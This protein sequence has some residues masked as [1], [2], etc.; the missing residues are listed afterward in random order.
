MK[1][2]VEIKIITLGASGVGKTS[3]IKRIKFGTFAEKNEAT[4]GVDYFVVK[5]K[6]QN[7]NIMI[8]LKYQDTNGL[9]SMQGIIPQQYIRDSQIVLLVFS[10]INTLNEVINRWYSFY[11]ENANIDKSKFILIGNKKDIFG[12]EKEEIERQGNQFAEEIDAHFITCSAKSA[13]NMD[14]LERYI[15]TEAKKFIDENEKKIVD[16]L[17][18][19]N[20]N[21]IDTKKKLN[22]EKKNCC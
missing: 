16:K 3:L 14:N 9:E 12:D 21:R 22:N 2:E 5:K 15:L 11:K 18:L 20:I 7:K 13:D 4:L 19:N 8:L 1:N 6:Y 17:K 10:N